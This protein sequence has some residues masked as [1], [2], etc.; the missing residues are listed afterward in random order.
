MKQG[1]SVARDLPPPGSEANTI[2][3][4]WQYVGDTPA[5]RQSYDSHTQIIRYSIVSHTPK[6][7]IYVADT[8]QIRQTYATSRLLMRYQYASCAVHL[9]ASVSPAYYQGHRPMSNVPLAYL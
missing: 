6:C 7:I 5:I 1:N 9:H 8:F 2:P 3:H 4:T